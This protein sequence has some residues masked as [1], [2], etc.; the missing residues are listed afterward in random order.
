M[1]YIIKRSEPY[2]LQ[3]WFKQET[4]IDGKRKRI[5]CGYDDMPSEV[6]A[7]VKKQLLEEQGWLCCYTGRSIDEHFSHIEHFK[8]QSKFNENNEDV[9][10]KNLLAAF[11]GSSASKCPYGAHAKDDWYDEKLVSPLNKDCEQRFSF[12]LVGEISHATGDIGSK[13]TIEHLKLNHDELNALRRSAIETALIKQRLSEKQ[14]HQIVQGYDAQD[15]RGR[16]RSF[17]FVIQQA[18]KLQLKKVENRRKTKMYSEH[19]RNK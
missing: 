10:Y 11:P 12:N 16:Y 6:K 18:A 15:K 13:E 5:N 1:K 17:C 7:A 9:D 2:E 3:H 19:A 4:V 14:L 8:P